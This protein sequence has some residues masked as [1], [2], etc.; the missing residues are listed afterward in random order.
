MQISIICFTF[1]LQFRNEEQ[2]KTVLILK[3]KVMDKEFRNRVKKAMDL[4]MYNSVSISF[5]VAIVAIDAKDALKIR[6]YI[7][8]NL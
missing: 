2:I 4:I 7:K 8:E 5:A 3:H 1:A 6:E